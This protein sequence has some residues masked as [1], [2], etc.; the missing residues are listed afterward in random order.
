[1][2]ITGRGSRIATNFAA[3]VVEAWS[4]LRVHRLRVL[5]SLIGVMV[6]VASLAGTAAAAD[7]A[8]QVIVEQQ[9]GQGRPAALQVFAADT[10]TGQLIPSARVRPAIARTAERFGITYVASR[11]DAGGFRATNGPRE[12]DLS[13]AVVDATYGPMHRIVPTTGRW[14]E[15]ADAQN[16]S[17]A[18]VVTE[19]LLRKLGL[20]GRPLPLTIE[21]TMKRPVTVTVVG[22]VPTGPYGDPGGYA[23]MLPDTYNHWFA[24]DSPLMDAAYEMWVPTQG[25]QELRFEVQRALQAELPGFN[26]QVDREDYLAW[27][28]EDPLREVRLVVSAIAGVIL[29]LGMLSLLNVALVTIQQRVREVGIRRSFGATTGRVFFSVMMESVVATAAAGTIGVMIAVAVISNPWIQ[30]KFIHGIDDPPPFPIDAALLGLAVSIGV[31]V[32]AGVLPAVVAAR[33]KIVDAIRF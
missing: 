26:V 28:G 17:P 31:G 23:F 14:L 8:Q 13:V 4:E 1:M 2:N 33:V 11:S 25:W 6:A 27:G 24:A 7:I 20:D 12:R 30:D 16:L 9:E 19:S 5:L 18:V 21:L 3:A 10:H 29:L 15:T 32:L 22:T